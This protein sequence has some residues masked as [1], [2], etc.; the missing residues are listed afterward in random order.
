MR[1]SLI[2][3]ASALTLGSGLALAQSP[4]PS[5][6]PPAKSPAA[7]AQPAGQKLSDADC[8]ATW[9][10]AIGSSKTT[11][12]DEASSKSYLPDFKA[13]DTNHDNKVDQTEWKSA[14]SNGLVVASA[15]HSGMGSG[16]AASGKNTSGEHPPTNRM[17]KMVPPMKAQ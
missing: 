2:A 1:T 6:A 16:S 9:Q 4:S 11:T 12:L 13:A 7:S 14:C 3:I 8:T 17:D 10:K 5:T 15:D